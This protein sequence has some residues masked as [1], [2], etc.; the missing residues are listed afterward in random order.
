M[1]G[2]IPLA[3]LILKHREK[4]AD[5]GLTPFTERLSIKGFTFANSNPGIWN[6]GVKIGAKVAGKFIRNGK[7][8]INVGALAEWTKAR[9][10][11]SAEGESFREWFANRK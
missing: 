8:P 10:L 9:D 4:I 2:E 5:A 11:P 1:S 3:Q 6:M 7:A